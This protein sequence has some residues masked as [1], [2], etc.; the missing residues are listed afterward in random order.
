LTINGGALDSTVVNLVNANNNAQTW[1]GSF[2]FA[3]SQNLNLGTG[4]VT[5]SANTTITVTNNTLTVGGAIT[6]TTRSLTK[7]GTG[8]LVLSGANTYSNTTVTAGTLAIAQATLNT[9]STVAISN[10]AALQLN[11]STTNQVAALIFGGTSQAGGVY[12]AANSGGLITGT[13][14][15]LVVPLTPPINTNAPTM[16]VSIAGGT[17]SLA[18]PTN[19][20]WILQSN[21]VGLAS[22][23][24][25]FNYP[26]NGA[27][28]VTNVNITI[29]PAKT[30]VFFRMLKP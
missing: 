10:S 28:D 15:L 14:A 11:F 20:G 23:S 8:T 29:N 12:K 13:G 25:W 18:W 19:A 22:S 7:S 6:G 16:Q 27:V 30:N 5:M 26:A 2:G 17:L 3:G 21:S 9:N 1:G 24:A 4:S